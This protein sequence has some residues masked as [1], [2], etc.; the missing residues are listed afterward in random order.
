MG[1]V[2]KVRPV[3]GYCCRCWFFPDPTYATQL[4][5]GA[6]ISR[7][8]YPRPEGDVL[9]DNFH[10]V[11]AYLNDGGAG[12]W[13]MIHEIGHALGLKHSFDD[14]GNVPD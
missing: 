9:L 2:G 6:G 8:E 1:A 5:N 12:Y 13:T 14:G 7:T 11:Y 3:L 4:I 10:P